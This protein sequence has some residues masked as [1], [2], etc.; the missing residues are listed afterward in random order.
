MKGVSVLTT[1]KLRKNDTDKAVVKKAIAKAVEVEREAIKLEKDTK[2][3]IEIQKKEDES[4]MAEKK[5]V[6][7]P[8]E[9][10]ETV[11]TVAKVTPAK[12]AEPVKT[13]E[14]VK[15]TVEAKSTAV[16]EEVFIQFGSNEVL[17]KDVVEKVKAAYVAE[18]HAA[19]SVKKVRIY[20]K[21]EE[22]MVYYVVNDDY[23]SGISLS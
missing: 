12:T 14:T 11:K 6:K 5:V 1:E 13:T 4:K 2:E 23:A 10:K 16:E 15:E 21:P 20:I 8:V 17:T 22:N 9:K 19:S 18:G 3:T 7:K